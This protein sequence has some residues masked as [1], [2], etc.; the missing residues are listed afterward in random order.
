ME[1]SFQGAKISARYPSVI[2][3]LT[4]REQALRFGWACKWVESFGINLNPT[5][6]A[7]YR[8]DLEDLAD[9]VKA[10][11]AVDFEKERGLENIINSV[12]EAQELIDIH[13]GLKNRQD[14]HLG[15]LLH[16]YIGGTELRS[17]ETRQTSRARNTGFHLWFVSTAAQCDVPI[18]LAPPADATIHKSDISVA[19]ECKRLFSPKKVEQN[20]RKGF[21]QLQERYAQHDGR[22]EIFGVLAVSLG[23]LDDCLVEAN[24]E[25]DLTAQ[26][27]AKLE[28]F[29]KEYERHWLKRITGREVSVFLHWTA[30][31]RV[32]NP[33]LLTTATQFHFYPLCQPD[34]NQGYILRSLHDRFHRFVT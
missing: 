2:D 28:R 1:I 20:I 24:D 11:T 25:A 23:K 18:D 14:A 3:R 13:A 16:E 7:I 6:A 12:V 34:T 8:R 15:D 22:T 17:R 27:N 4:H 31:V 32:K 19:V 21:Q 29:R 5:R 9:H 10:K 26:S 30:P 33:Y